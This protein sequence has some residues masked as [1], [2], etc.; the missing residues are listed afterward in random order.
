MHIKQR[1]AEST[2]IFD[3][4]GRLMHNNGFGE[5]KTCAMPLLEDGQPQLL[6]NMAEV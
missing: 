4:D 2:V 3:L 1:V 5:V 6:L